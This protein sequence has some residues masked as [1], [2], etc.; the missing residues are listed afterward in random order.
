MEKAIARAATLN[1]VDYAEYSSA[2]INQR[3]SNMFS[4]LNGAADMIA[5]EENIQSPQIM[6]MLRRNA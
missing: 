6:M 2:E 3:I 1:L 4:S 5:R